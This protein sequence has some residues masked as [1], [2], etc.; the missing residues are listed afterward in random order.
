MSKSLEEGVNKADG[1]PGEGPGLV[2]VATG[3]GPM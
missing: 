2:L 1:T 3:Q